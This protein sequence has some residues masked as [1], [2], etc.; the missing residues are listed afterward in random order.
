MIIMALELLTI[1]T[2]F[3]LCTKFFFDRHIQGKEG[4]DITR[5]KI[6]SLVNRKTAEAAEARDLRSHYEKYGIETETE[7]ED[8][9]IMLVNKDNAIPDNYDIPLMCFS[10]GTLI[11]ERIYTPLDEMFYAMRAEG[12]YPQVLEAYRSRDMQT[13]MMEEKVN[14]FLK[15]GLSEKETKESAT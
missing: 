7:S 15:E 13:A 1:C 4:Y 9:E 14:Y 10:D 5:R 6:S 8:W 11:D 2:V 12:I 3:L